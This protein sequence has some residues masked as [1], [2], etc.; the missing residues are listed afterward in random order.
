VIHLYAIVRG[1]AA[2]PDRAGIGGAQLDAKAVDDVVAVTSILSDEPEPADGAVAHG[3]VVEA[4][5]DVADAVVPVRYGA[6]FPDAAALVATVSGQLPA[7]R[8]RLAS[9]EGCVELSVRLLAS[10]DA[11][12]V[13]TDGTAYMQERLH[14]VRA[15]E[16][17]ADAVHEPLARR[18]RASVRHRRLDRAVVHDGC[19]LVERQRTDAFRSLVEA[20]GTDHP[21]VTV[22]CTGPWAPYNFAVAPERAA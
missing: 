22:V 4:L 14:A 12:T 20:F 17:L 15:T 19:Y 7:L 5:V 6:R 2:L 11:P 3:L 18:A 8:E 1:L 9:V 13:A 10:D 16:Q 21:E